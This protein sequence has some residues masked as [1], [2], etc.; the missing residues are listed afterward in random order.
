MPQHFLGAIGWLRPLFFPKADAIRGLC[1]VRKRPEGARLTL[2]EFLKLRVKLWRLIDSNQNKTAFS[3]AFGESVEQ[4]RPRLPIWVHGG[5]TGEGEFAMS[6]MRHRWFRIFIAM[7]VS[8]LAI[9]ACGSADDLSVSEAPPAS[10]SNA[11]TKAAPKRPAN[12]PSE[13]VVTPHGY[14]HPACIAEL[15]EDESMRADH[16]I[17]GKNGHVRDIPGC[18]FPHYDK[19]GNAVQATAS[20]A[21]VTTPSYSGWVESANN[22]SMGPLNWI[23]A[24]WK[25]PTN[26]AMNNGQVLYYFPGFEPLSTGGFIMQ[27]VLGYFGNGSWTIA[28]WNCCVDNTVVKGPDAPVNQNDTLYGYVQGKNCDPSGVCSDWQIYTGDW[29]TGTYS[30]LNTSSLGQVMDWSFGGVLEAYYIDDCAE[31]PQS[32][33]VTFSNVMVRNAKDLQVYPVWSTGTTGGSPSCGYGVTS[34]NTNT[35]T[36]ATKATNRPAPAAPSA[37]GTLRAG[38]RF[39]VGKSLTSCD[40]RFKLTL[41]TTGNL[42]LYQGAKVLWSAGT[43]GSNRYALETMTNGDVVLWDSTSHRVWGTNTAW[44]GDP[45]TEYLSLGND[46]N[47]AVRTASG[48]TVWST[49]T[50]GH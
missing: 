9:V 35:V 16:R 40:G 31:Y 20:R 22:T 5:R 26:P 42:V 17:H 33:G 25:V 1:V 36:V 13:F 3:A 46:G 39:T 4:R 19:H 38:E 15:S 2:L 48:A 47:L 10:V 18:D 7:P 44:Y 27:P 49:N 41:A 6:R 23:S 14:F 11:I 34:P 21:P 30:M 28:S 24:N 45:A 37:C 29:N 32:G 50:G 8:A 43:T 12:V